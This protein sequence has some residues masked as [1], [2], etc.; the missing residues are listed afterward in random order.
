MLN[1]FN[2]KK[3]MAIKVFKNSYINITSKNVEQVQYL[4]KNIHKKLLFK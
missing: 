2:I 3:K 4:K 1:K